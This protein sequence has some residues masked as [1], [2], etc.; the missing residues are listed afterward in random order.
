[1]RREVELMKEV[2]P[3]AFQLYFFLVNGGAMMDGKEV[4]SWFGINRS[5][6]YRL[7]RELKEVGLVVEERSVSG[8]AISFPFAHV[9]EQPSASEVLPPPPPVIAEVV[10]E[11]PKPVAV[12]QPKPDNQTAVGTVI[13]VMNNAFNPRTFTP[14]QVQ[15]LLTAAQGD[16]DL[17]TTVVQK[18]KA[19]ANVNSPLGYVRKA[20][21]SELTENKGREKPDVSG[22][23]VDV[24][25]WVSQAKKMKGR[26]FEQEYDPSERLGRR[27]N[28]R[29][30]EGTG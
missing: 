13:R 22:E 16:V 9:T 1:M 3:K 17:I 26:D 19:P 6:R 7:M 15:Q 21:A 18:I 29:S 11:E 24:E 23:T 14:P 30:S 2:S 25:Y 5:Y 8:I 28:R 4:E 20:I 27:L 12:I 10:K